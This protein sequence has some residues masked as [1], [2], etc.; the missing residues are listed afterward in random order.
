[1]ER[2]VIEFLANAFWQ[3]PLLAT[4]AWLL[5][6]IIKPEPEVQHRVWLM[7]LGLALVLPLRG[8]IDRPAKIQRAA[9]VAVQQAV[10]S[11]IAA[12]SPNAFDAVGQPGG[13]VLGHQTSGAWP[14][15]SSLAFVSR[16]REVQ[17]NAMAVY[18]I[19]GAYLAVLLVGIVR[20]ARAWHGARRLTTESREIA[21]TDR[22]QAAVAESA[23][24]M[25]VKPPQVR[26][27]HASQSHGITGPVV[28]GAIKPVLLWEG[29]FAADLFA[30]EREDEL[31]AALCHEM[32]HIRRHDYLTNLLCET[33]ALPLKW[34][35]VTYAIEGRI[36]TT[37]E[38]ACDA[39]AAEAMES[40]TK[41][42]NCL[43]SLA[44]SMV[45]AGNVAEH[46]VGAAA[47]GLFG[48]DVLEERMMR[49]MQAKTE[50][51]KRARAIRC[52]TGGAAM[53]ATVALAAAF[54]VIPA[55][56]QSQATSVDSTAALSPAKAAAPTK[57]GAVS[58]AQ[59]NVVGGG[60]AS[61]ARVV[62]VSP[63][64]KVNPVVHVA[65]VVHVVPVVHVEPLVQLASVAPLVH[66]EPVINVASVTALV[67]VAPVVSPVVHVAPLMP[68]LQAAPSAP[69]APSTPGAETPAPPPPPATPPDAAQKAPPAP[70]APT[71]PI[72]N[73]S[74]CEDDDYA[75]VDGVRRKLTAE[76]HRQLDARLAAVQKKLAAEMARINSPEFRKQI[77][78]ARLDAMEAEKQINSAEFQKQMA[79][80]Q[81]QIAEATARLNS[82]EFRQQMEKAQRDAMEAAKQINS[83][84]FQ[85]QM[86][87]A[88][89][90]LAEA[91]ARMKAKQEKDDSK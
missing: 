24:R 26:E 12:F 71:A 51:S 15:F 40:E 11:S 2:K 8:A 9:A 66:V 59:V 47:L 5:L 34:H 88:Q 49:L 68:M 13:L 54:H 69:A 1:M 85:K 19:M 31:M 28:V 42:A 39:M 91:L 58:G 21:L 64:V 22:E 78:K 56:A 35:P 55:M 27:L 48:N 89:K 82:P 10:P 60:D 41:Y 44:Q 61:N 83:A 3:L 18:W 90:Q 32:A 29:N 43:L 23:R 74:R 72:V 63:V 45:A 17:L 62:K 86:A 38:M 57:E 79:D 7:V 16:V 84:E 65:P 36:R 67:H 53:M 87:D 80:A 52:V 77:E 33:A 50:I 37:R 6:R 14:S 76:E 75:I 4:G 25:G 20:F 46:S 70:A 73:H 81:K 30:R